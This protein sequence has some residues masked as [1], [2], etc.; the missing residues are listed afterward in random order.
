MFRVIKLF[1]YCRKTIPN[2]FLAGLFPFSNFFTFF[3]QKWSFSGEEC[4]G[5]TLSKLQNILY[6]HFGPIENFFSFFFYLFYYFFFFF[7]FVCLFVFFFILISI[8]QVFHFPLF[9]FPLFHFPLL[10]LTAYTQ[11]PILKILS[12][13]SN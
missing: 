11:L 8:F 3:G 9:H 12:I 7:F 2:V 10:N 6:S 4:G 13:L 1:N 5:Q